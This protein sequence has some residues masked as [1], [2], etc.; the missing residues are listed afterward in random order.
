[1]NTE[2]DADDFDYKYRDGLHRLGPARD[3]GSNS[4]RY[5]VKPKTG[6]RTNGGCKCD[7]CPWCGANVRPPIYHRTWCEHKGWNPGDPKPLTDWPT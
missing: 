4:C 5:A 6:M 1:V 7:E 2:D 3:C